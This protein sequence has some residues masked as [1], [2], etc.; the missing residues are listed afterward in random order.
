[1]YPSSSDP[2]LNIAESPH[3]R[4][5]SSL[6]RI[7][8]LWLLALAPALVAA[9]LLHGMLAMR[10]LGLAVGSAV[11]FDALTNRLLSSRDNTGNWSS[12]T[13][14]LLI[15]FL[16]PVNAPWWLVLVAS[17]MTIVIGKKL[18]GGW[19]AYP[20]HP[21]A[22]S[23]AMLHVS[24]PAR[25]D[26]TASMV[27]SIWN[28]S[29]VEPLRLVKTLGAGAEAYY[30]KMDLLMGIQVGG[31]GNAQVLWL[32]LG[33]FFLLLMRQIPWRIPVGFIAGL[34]LCAWFLE[35]V[36][37][38]RTA[39]PLFHL[40][41]GSTILTAFYL[42]PE[43]TTS[44]VNPWPMLIYG[45]MGGILMM[46]IRAFSNHTDGAIFAVLLMNLVSPLLDRIQPRVIGLE[47]N[48]DA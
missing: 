21:V 48:S 8:L 34:L 33:G 3:W 14:G 12:V 20:V 32:F 43:H 4:D 1:M 23:Y 11:M 24:W 38:G 25:L 13:M 30:D 37:P 7:Q 35:L 40:L 10:I 28:G 42:L 36:A 5:G 29:I 44:P 19:G 2:K 18:F 9:L 15:A 41:A 27:N 46:L 16:L 17:F 45:I 47:V 31:T 6:A 26:C 39:S 22:L